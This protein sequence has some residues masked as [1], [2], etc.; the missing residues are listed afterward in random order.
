[1]VQEIAAAGFRLVEDLDF[2]RTNYF[3]RFAPVE[4]SNSH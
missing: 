1:V 2:L 3:L 4:G